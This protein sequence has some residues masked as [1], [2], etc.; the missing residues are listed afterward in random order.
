MAVYS[1]MYILRLTI[2][3][4][5]MLRTLNTVSFYPSQQYYQYCI[6][7]P[8]LFIGKLSLRG[9][10]GHSQSHTASKRQRLRLKTSVVDL[11]NH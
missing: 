3:L 8:A 4:G 5:N 7:S 6:H 1:T 10:K 11:C 2:M 9:N